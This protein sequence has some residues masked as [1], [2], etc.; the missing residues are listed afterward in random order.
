MSIGVSP[1]FLPTILSSLPGLITATLV[2]VGPAGASLFTYLATEVLFT[3]QPSVPLSAPA[4]MTNE[5]PAL[6]LAYPKSNT[7][8]IV[9]TSV[10]DPFVKPADLSLAT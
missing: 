9:A 10:T 2:P 4:G 5:P 8:S 7:A 3:F 1:R 6:P